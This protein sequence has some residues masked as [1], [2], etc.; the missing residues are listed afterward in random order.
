MSDNAKLLLNDLFPKFEQELDDEIDSNDENYKELKY[1]VC[2]G[3][4]NHFPDNSFLNIVYLFAEDMGSLDH[5][6]NYYKNYMN[7]P[8]TFLPDYSSI[9][10]ENALLEE[11]ATGAYNSGYVERSIGSNIQWATSE[12]KHL[13][14][15]KYPVKIDEEIMLV[16]ENGIHPTYELYVLSQNIFEPQESEEE[17]TPSEYD[18]ELYELDTYYFDLLKCKFIPFPL[19]LEN[20][21]SILNGELPPEMPNLYYCDDLEYK[22]YVKGNMSQSSVDK[23]IELRSRIHKAFDKKYGIYEDE[24]DPEEYNHHC[25]YGSSKYI[26]DDEYFDIVYNEVVNNKSKKGGKQRK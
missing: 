25:H 3:S 1:A 22:P 6:F 9:D 11:D 17:E 5:A 24:M 2:D 16:F 10:D 19:T 14:K 21:M 8:N 26:F 13:G 7:D 23:A 4:R 12:N 18:Y 20:R 15:Y